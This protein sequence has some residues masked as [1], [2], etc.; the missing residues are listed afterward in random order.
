MSIVTVSNRLQRREEST[1]PRFTS[2]SSSQLKARPIHV[3]LREGSVTIQTAPCPL[4]P[5]DGREAPGPT[6]LCWRNPWVPSGPDGWRTVWLFDRVSSEGNAELVR[7]D[8]TE[9][10]HHKSDRSRKRQLL[11]ESWQQPSGCHYRN[12]SNIQQPTPVSVVSKFLAFRNSFTFSNNA[13]GI[14]GIHV[15][16]VLQSTLVQTYQQRTT[17]VKV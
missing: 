14:R 15:I 13:N 5:I 10:G 11:P 12:D 2:F 8:L 7:P 4:S 17:S 3:E 16:T 9:K 6:Y 1:R